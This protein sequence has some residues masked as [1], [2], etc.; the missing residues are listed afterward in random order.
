[1]GYTVPNFGLDHDINDSL[2]HLKQNEA[3]YGQW[4]LPKDD[5]FL[6]T[7]AK[8]EPL[9]TWAPSPHK[10]HPVNY[11]VP[12]FGKDKDLVDQDT[13]MSGA[14]AGLKHQ[15]TPK[16][17]DKDEKFNVPTESAEF[18]LMQQ[19]AEINREPLLTW[20][21]TGHKSFKA[22]YFVPN[23]GADGDIVTSQKNIGDTEKNLSHVWNWAPPAKPNKMGYTVPN[24]GMDHD[25]NDSLNHLKNQEA[26]HGS[27]NL[28]KDDWF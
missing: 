12:N 19:L 23:F 9:L 16:W 5:W 7:E 3:Q 10:G 1:M 24:F 21:P 8:R 28:P 6:Q 20:A 22:D 11:F 13:H 26:T 2:S 27:W 14:E 18:K 17:D 15:W 25:I 4:D